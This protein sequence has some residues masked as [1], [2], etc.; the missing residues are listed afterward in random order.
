MKF[1][2]EMKIW[3][4]CFMAFVLLV[5]DTLLRPFGIRLMSDGEIL[6][7][8]DATRLPETHKITQRL[9]CTRTIL[10]LF[11]YPIYACFFELL[12]FGICSYFAY[13]PAW[14]IYATAIVF[15]ALPVLLLLTIAVGLYSMWLEHLEDKEL[16]SVDY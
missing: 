1:L 12:A 11:Q 13:K 4:E 16:L 9:N 14:L 15:I 3:F 6:A 5:F 7:S 10:S 8:Q 2:R